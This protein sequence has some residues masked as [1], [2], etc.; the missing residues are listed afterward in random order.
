MQR[1][2][3][4][5]RSLS[6]MRGRRGTRTALAVAAAA[7]ALTAL[8]G[9]GAASPAG[10]PAPG[11]ADARS[12]SKLRPFR[13]DVSTL[14]A[15]QR[16]RMTGKSWHEGCPVGLG[17]LREVSV[18]YLD[19]HKRA[20][21]GKLIIRDEHAD[22]IVRVFRRLYAKR[23]PIRRI[24]PIDRYGGDDH[25]SMDADNT[26]AFNCRVVNGTSRWSRH[27]YGDALDLNPRENPYVT[28]SGFVSPAAGEAYADRDDVRKGMVESKNVVKIFRRAAGWK[29]GGDWSGTK[30]YQHFTATG[31]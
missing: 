15:K 13:G 25:R 26:S 27:A 7:A 20:Q 18:S 31:R 4:A 21:Q 11:T 9:A 29:W 30:D 2:D 5:P 16:K 14:S 17:E 6:P 22:A 28:S 19:F 8:P 1:A 23:F 12:A 24:E 3:Q 10:F